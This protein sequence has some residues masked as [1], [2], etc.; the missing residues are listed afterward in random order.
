MGGWS[1]QDNAYA[2]AAAYDY[3]AAAVQPLCSLPGL[4]A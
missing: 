2:V 1:E 3:A 4:R